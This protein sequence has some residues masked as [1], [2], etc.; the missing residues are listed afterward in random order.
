M[1]KESIQ[2]IIDVSDNLK[3]L[4]IQKL[5]AQERFESNVTFGHSGGLFKIDS[6]LLTYVSYLLQ[7]GKIND[8]VI[9][10]SNNSPI[11]VK[12]VNSFNKDI[13]DAYYTA[14]DI[15]HNDIKDLN[16]LQKSTARYLDLE[17]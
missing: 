17:S 11:L 2:H 14:L 8:T 4:N 7:N 10:D 5:R 12:D 13:Q 1:N 16:I 9:L 3:T 15:Y 6:T